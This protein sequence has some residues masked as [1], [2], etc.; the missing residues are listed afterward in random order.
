MIVLMLTTEW[1]FLKIAGLTVGSFAIGYVLCVGL[2][3]VAAKRT[4]SSGR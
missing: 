1:G 2:L 4:E 3:L